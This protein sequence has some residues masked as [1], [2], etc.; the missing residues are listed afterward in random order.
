MRRSCLLALGVM[1]FAAI[2]LAQP[3]DLKPVHPDETAKQAF[4]ERFSLENGLERVAF[5]RSAL[6][7]FV[8]LRVKGDQVIGN[9]DDGGNLNARQVV[10]WTEFRGRL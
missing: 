5:V 4:G 10:G 7:S 6:E 2:L 3:A 1:L 9:L 8:K